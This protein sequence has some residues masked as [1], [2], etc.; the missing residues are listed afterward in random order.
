MLLTC[1]ND[2][3]DQLISHMTLKTEYGDLQTLQDELKIYVDFDDYPEDYAF[4]DEFKA[5][6]EVL[7]QNT[8]DIWF[9]TDAK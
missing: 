6:L 5:T 4:I 3:S 9:K 8:E 1:L 7:Q 2:N